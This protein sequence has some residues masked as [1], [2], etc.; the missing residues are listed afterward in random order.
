[1]PEPPTDR[2]NIGA[3]GD[4]QAG[5]GVPQAVKAHARQ[6]LRADRPAPIPAQIV[7]RAQLVFE[8]A[9]YKLGR[10]ALP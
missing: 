7:R 4:H 3:G 8:G 10:T 9:E 2:Q 5:A 6:P 1:M